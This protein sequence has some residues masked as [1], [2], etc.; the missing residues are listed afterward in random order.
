MIRHIE[1]LI[2]HH[3]CVVIPGFGAIIAHHIPAHLDSE[4]GCMFPPSRSIGFNPD[5]NHNDGLLASSMA[6]GLSTSFD[7]ASAILSNDVSALKMQLDTS[8]EYALGRLGILSRHDNGPIMFEPF[9]STIICP[10]Y[11]GLTATALTPVAEKI[12]EEA[13][14]AEKEQEECAPLSRRILNVAASVALL[15][16]LGITF[17]TPLIENKANLAGF[18]G[19]ASTQQPHEEPKFEL[20]E[21]PDIDLHIALP[22][23]DSTTL[24]ILTTATA[25]DDACPRMNSSDRY[26]LV[27]ASLPSRDKA[28]QFVAAQHSGDSLGI[29]S[30]G[31]RYRVYVATGTSVEQARKPMSTA[32]YASRYPDAWVCRR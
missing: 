7:N 24:S 22:A 26:F 17:S 30:T 5:I 9:A 11:S 1:Y 13:V 28:E 19:I 32:S 10:A 2:L 20:V 31:S 23:N 25:A 3:D 12:K 21:Q 6:R 14:R 18:G 8:G 27:V 4:L 16:C 29:I 15:L